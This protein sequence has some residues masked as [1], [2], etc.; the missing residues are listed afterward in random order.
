MFD[1]NGWGLDEQTIRM[2][3]DIGLD[4][5]VITGYT[6]EEYQRFK[7]IKEKLFSD[8]SFDRTKKI[9]N[10]RAVSDEHTQSKMSMVETYSVFK[11]DERLDYYKAG[12]G[13]LCNVNISDFSCVKLDTLL[14]VSATGEV[15]MC[16]YDWKQTVS[17]GNLYKDSLEDI[18]TNK[19]KFNDRAYKQSILPDVCTRCVHYYGLRKTN[20]Q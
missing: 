3:F 18:I 2:L 5:I 17:F 13:Q 8:E 7:N 9:L 4:R 10:V 14:C 19:I 11:L 6:D 20:E 16:E 1:T 12:E 15:T